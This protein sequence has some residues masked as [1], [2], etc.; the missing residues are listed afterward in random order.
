MPS[1]GRLLVSDRIVL[2]ASIFTPQPQ[3][4]SHSNVGDGTRGCHDTGARGRRARARHVWQRVCVAV[5]S[6]RNESNG[7]SRAH[8]PIRMHHRP[9]TLVPTYQRTRLQAPPLTHPPT[10]SPTHSPTCTPATHVPNHS[11]GHV[12]HLIHTRMRA[13]THLVYPTTG[14]SVECSVGRRRHQVAAARQC[15]FSQ[16]QPS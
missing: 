7:E 9:P 11:L 15:H 1:C 14:P 16:R 5:D 12:L 2:T 13:L 10:Y 3:V 8:V 6:K 4:R